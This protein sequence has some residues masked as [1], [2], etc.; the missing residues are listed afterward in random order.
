MFLKLYWLDICNILKIQ[1]FL[2]VQ[3]HLYIIF[4]TDTNVALK[5]QS[6]PRDNS[7]REKAVCLFAFRVYEQQSTGNYCIKILGVWE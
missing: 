5:W 3:L 7:F 2:N 4:F 6:E 1:Y